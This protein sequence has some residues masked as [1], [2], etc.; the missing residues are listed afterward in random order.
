MFPK[1][2]NPK[3]K[4]INNE[5]L[6]DDC[7]ICQAMKKAQERGY[8]LSYEELQTAFAEANKLQSKSKTVN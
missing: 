5:D 3:S 1:T 2:K 6:F 8:D 7:P 4:K